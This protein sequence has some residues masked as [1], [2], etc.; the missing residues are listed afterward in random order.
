MKI[1]IAMLISSII[2]IASFNS[3]AKFVPQGGL[4]ESI[5][6][7]NT[8]APEQDF[9]RNIWIKNGDNNAVITCDD[10]TCDLTNTWVFR[11]LKNQDNNNQQGYIDP[12]IQQEIFKRLEA[13]RMYRELHRKW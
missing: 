3:H 5:G 1:L 12:R 4:Y 2:A 11:D 13:E 7:I 9:K 8:H 10:T 6:R